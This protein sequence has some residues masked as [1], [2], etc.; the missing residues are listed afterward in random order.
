MTDTGMTDTGPM[1][2]VGTQF[3]P[4]RLQRLLGR[5]CDLPAC[6]ER[7]VQRGNRRQHLRVPAH[8]QSSQIATDMAAKVP[9]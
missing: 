6:A 3:G 5:G 1:S 2:R 4:Y 8:H 9:T 7:D